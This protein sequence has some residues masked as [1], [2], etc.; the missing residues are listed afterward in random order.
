MLLYTIISF[1][2]INSILVATVT[3]ELAVRNLVYR[4]NPVSAV[5]FHFT[6]RLLRLVRLIS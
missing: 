5:V 2:A 4:F 6:R 3:T 1:L